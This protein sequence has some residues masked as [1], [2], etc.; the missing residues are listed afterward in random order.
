M[1]LCAVTEVTNLQLRRAAVE[2]AEETEEDE[3]E[4][5]EAE[6]AEEDAEPIAA[7]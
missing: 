5:E 2:P 6:E 7:E 3:E 4:A 1:R